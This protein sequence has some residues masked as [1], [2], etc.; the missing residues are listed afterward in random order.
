MTAATLA[1]T[2]TLRNALYAACT[3]R[4]DALLDLLDALLV[5]GPCPS[6]VQLSLSAPHRR[7]WGSLYAALAAGR[8][9]EARLRDRVAALPL[10]HAPSIGVSDRPIGYRRLKSQA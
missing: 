9:A 6:L 10:A 8:L 7:G 4:A 3:R 5:G 1:A 2:K